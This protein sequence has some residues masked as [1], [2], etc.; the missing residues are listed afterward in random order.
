MFRARNNL[1]PI[2][3]QNRFNQRDGGYNLNG[4]KI[5]KRFL[6]KI[7][8]SVCRA[9]LWNGLG[10]KHLQCPDIQKNCVQRYDFHTVQG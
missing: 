7:C 5:F 6:N 10:A 2:N 1:L 8:V 4:N 9:Q 3:I